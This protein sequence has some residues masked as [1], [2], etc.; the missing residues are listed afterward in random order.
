MLFILYVKKISKATNAT[1]NK[2]N[3]SPMFCQWS[4]LVGKVKLRLSFIGMVSFF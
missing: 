1:K 3:V 4:A 2:K